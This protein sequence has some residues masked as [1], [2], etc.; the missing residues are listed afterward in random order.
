MPF[1]PKGDRSLRVI[2]AEMIAKRSPGDLVTY[3]EFARELRI[4]EDDRSQIRQAISSARPTVLRDYNLALVAVRNEGYRVALP[5]EYAGIAQSHRRRS[6]RQIG[7]ALAIIEY[8]PVSRMSSDELERYRAVAI[9]IRNLHSRVTS[10]ENR[11]A[12]LEAAVYGKSKVQ[13]TRQDS[14]GVYVPT[15]Q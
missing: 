3:A 15:G 10:A 14:R 9:T 8:A 1:H 11:L 12:D 13:E 7:K 4:P 6:D 5:G 2:V